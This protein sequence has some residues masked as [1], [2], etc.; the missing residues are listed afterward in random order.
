MQNNCTNK[1]NSNNKVLNFSRWSRK[2]YAVF[3]SIGRIV[4]ISNLKIEVS[5]SFIKKNKTFS[6]IQTLFN[7]KGNTNEE[8]QLDIF[9]LI[10]LDILQFELLTNNN[11]KK[12]NSDKIKLSNN[13]YFNNIKCMNL[14]HAFFVFTFYNNIIN[15]TI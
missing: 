4:K 2:S 12:C 14:I 5:Q 13:T 3:V 15:L 11:S 10:K 1:S 9:E 7:F 6:A 8:I